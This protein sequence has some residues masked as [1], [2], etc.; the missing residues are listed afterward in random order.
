MPLSKQDISRSTAPEKTPFRVL[1]IGELMEWPDPEPRI[2]GILDK[3]T[4][5][6]LAG[7]YGTGKSFL[8]LDWAGCIATGQE[9]LGHVVK[10]GRVLYVAA[11]GAFG[12]KKRIAAWQRVNEKIE[13]GHFRFIIDP[14]QFGDET[15]LAA[16]QQLVCDYKIDFVV[17]DTLARCSVGLEE[18]SARDMGIFIDAL[19]ELRDVRGE[20][21]TD[22]LVVHHSGYEKHRA[23]GSTAISANVDNV[24]QVEAEDP[25]VEFTVT[26]TKR[27]D[28]PPIEPITLRLAES[29]RSCV[30]EAIGEVEADRP[31]L[32]SL[33]HPE[34]GH[35]VTELAELMHMSAEGVRK[36]LLAME[37][38]GTARREAG[39]GNQGD[40]WY[41]S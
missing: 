2:E 37:S 31:S 33:L 28:G 38:K 25:H 34:V 40:L 5:T 39:R 1:T 41:L 15:H 17:I 14:V 11:E 16:I 10:R 4:V 7:S 26:T 36:Q 29:G 3:G 19:Y 30:I 12:M 23:R 32:E 13:D 35:T 22:V 24:Y 21:K 18:N 6:L 27:K 20:G 9:W 8:A